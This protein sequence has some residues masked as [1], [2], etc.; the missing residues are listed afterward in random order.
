[1]KYTK[2]LHE[3]PVKAQHVSGGHM[4]HQGKPAK[5]T[6]SHFMNKS[7]GSTPHPAGKSNSKGARKWNHG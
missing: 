7:T 4:G 6:P 2:A 3:K 1:M 5:M